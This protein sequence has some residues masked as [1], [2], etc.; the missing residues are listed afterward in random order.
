MFSSCCSTTF[1]ELGF[2]SQGETCSPACKLGE[3]NGFFKIWLPL[4]TCCTLKTFWHS[5]D[6]DHVEHGVLNWSH[7]MIKVTSSCCCLHL[8]FPVDLVVLLDYDSQDID[9]IGWT[10]GFC[11]LNWQTFPGI[12]VFDATQ[13]LPFNIIPGIRII[14]ISS[15]R[16][17]EL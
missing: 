4:F 6:L 14:T 12:K 16:R 2:Y 10:S 13:K 5:T 17:R 1:K 8:V 3:R 15:F 11:F 9:K 7:F